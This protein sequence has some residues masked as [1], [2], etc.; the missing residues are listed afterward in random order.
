VAPE[1]AS[2]IRVGDRVEVGSGFLKGRLGIVQEL[3][4]RGGVR[5]AFGALSSRLDRPDVIGHGPA[6]GGRG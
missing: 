2:D 6:Q 5:I 3:D 1:R 4:D